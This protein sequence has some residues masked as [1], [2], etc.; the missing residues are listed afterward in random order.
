MTSQM[1]DFSTEL[2][3]EW[4]N[5]NNE[6]ETSIRTLEDIL[7]SDT[8]FAAIDFDDIEKNAIAF[9]SHQN[10][11]ISTPFPL[12]EHNDDIGF[13][14]D[15]SRST[16]ILHDLY[17]TEDESDDESS[18]DLNFTDFDFPNIIKECLNTDGT[19]GES[20][21]PIESEEEVTNQHDT[22]P[23]HPPPPP[24]PST[25]TSPAEPEEETTRAE[26]LTNNQ[27]HDT[28]PPPP[29]PPHPIK[30]PFFSPPDEVPGPHA[31]TPSK[32]LKKKRSF[33]PN[34]IP[35]LP[36]TAKKRKNEQH[37]ISSKT[38]SSETIT[39]SHPLTKTYKKKPHFQAFKK[40]KKISTDKIRK[41]TENEGTRLSIKSF[42]DIYH[43]EFRELVLD[44][45]EKI[46][47]EQREFRN[48][49]SKI[50]KLL[51]EK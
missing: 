34:G 8:D 40:P 41:K 39:P 18:P 14:V 32:K 35:T 24:V 31:P 33:F 50:Y 3:Q 46:E 51:S 17:Y 25:S 20:V 2:I 27:Q 19:V 21:A 16:R 12:M 11:Y 44:K 37:T 29:P 48:K 10:H 38:K 28:A 42:N 26:E 15:E 22:T 47:A 36:T 45:L 9:A 4:V 7:N 23:P 1:E 43:S 13:P 49:I 30:L 5:I 6:N